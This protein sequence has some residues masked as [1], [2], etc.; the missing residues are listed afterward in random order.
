MKSKCL[1]PEVENYY[2]L[3]KDLNLRKIYIENT[4]LF[5]NINYKRYI[6]AIIQNIHKNCNLCLTFK[7]FIDYH[8]SYLQNFM[9]RFECTGNLPYNL[10][11]N[12]F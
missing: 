7:G 11:G 12:R 1:S 5:I 8:L 4:L 3:V 6:K 9:S 10:I 2:C